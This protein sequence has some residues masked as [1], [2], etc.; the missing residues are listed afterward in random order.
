MT[1]T[2]ITLLYDNEVHTPGLRMGWGFACLIQRGQETLLFDT[3]W[4]FDDV[5]H[6]A[7][8]LGIDLR[9]VTTVFVSHNHWDHIGGLSRALSIIGSRPRLCLPSEIKSQHRTEI[10][11]RA[12]L[13]DV[14]TEPLAIAPGLTSTG[15]LTGGMVD[16]QALLIDTPEGLA[17]ITGCAHPGLGAILERAKRFGA[18]S[19]VIG[20]M[21]DFADI[22]E[23]GHVQVIVPCHCTRHKTRIL[24][25]HAGRTQTGG[26]GRV[27]EL[28]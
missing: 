21:H 18:I 22:D 13:I 2:R 23:L 16:E 28:S 12:K 8:Q 15:E 11:R 17:V 7:E 26:A 10:G 27:I 20:G 19:T 24:E 3:A 6:N 25:A 4:D 9:R 14:S 5:A 1:T